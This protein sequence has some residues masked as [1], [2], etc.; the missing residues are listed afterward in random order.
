REES[1][2]TGQASHRDS[3]SYRQGQN[4][5]NGRSD[6]MADDAVRSCLRS[7]SSTEIEYSADKR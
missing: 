2:C 1:G 7:L 3:P 6:P 5:R 4:A